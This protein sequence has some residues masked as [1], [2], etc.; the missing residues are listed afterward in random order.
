MSDFIEFELED[1]ATHNNVAFQ[2][3]ITQSNTKKHKYDDKYNFDSN[4]TSYY[5]ATRTTKMDP[6]TFDNHNK[7]FFE[8]TEMWDPY[9]GDR[10]E[11]DPHGPICFNPCNLIKFFYMKRLDGLWKKGTDDNTG[12]YQGYYDDAV[13]AGKNIEIVGRGMFPERY[14]F[15]LPI[16]DCYLTDDHNSNYVTMGPVLTENE[17]IKIDELAESLDNTPLSYK[18]L[19]GIDKPKLHKIMILYNEAIANDIPDKDKKNREAVEALKKM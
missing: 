1:D 13:G 7:S 12:V 6:I 17:I 19:H 2:D 11:I 14:L 4:T 3:N 5:V 18:N 16:Y 15:R 10:K 9:T 8:F